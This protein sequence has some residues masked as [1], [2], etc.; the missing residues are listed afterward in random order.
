MA[1]FEEIGKKISQTGQDM[2]QKTKD[3][4]ETMRL[5][6]AI[7]D[8]EKRM[9]GLYAEIG[10]RYFELHADSYEPELEELVLSVKECNTRIENYSEQIKRLKGIVRCPHCN[11]EVA[12][13]A[14]FCS[15]CGSKMPDVEVETAVE[16]NVRRCKNCG[17]PL[18]DGAGFCTNCGTQ[19]AP[20]PEEANVRRCVRC[21]QVLP[22]GVLFCTGCGTKVESAEAAPV[23]PVYAA[24]AQ[25]LCP[26]CGSV[27]VEGMAFCTY[28]GHQIP[29]D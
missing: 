19:A 24:P 22:D 10:Q 6:S 3:T 15:T 4:A 16:S 25:R 7:S 12:Y 9:Q 5:N 21:S 28:C 8:E 14:P 1:F 2:V 29:L 11:G 18:A 20:S 23:P 17:L 26:A 13:G 27:A